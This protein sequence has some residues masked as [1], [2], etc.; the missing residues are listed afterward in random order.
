M[1]LLDV[2][3]VTVDNND[4]AI[5]VRGA[6][7][8]VTVRTDTGPI[9]VTDVTGAV[10]ASSADGGISLDGISGSVA[11][12]TRTGPIDANGLSGTR[13]VAKTLDG[14]ITLALSTAQDVEAHSQTGPISLTV[15]QLAGGYRISTQTVTGPTDV[16]VDSNPTAARSIVLDSQDGGIT[17]N[18]A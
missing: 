3:T 14:S 2:G 9:S 5:A 18:P 15:P 12:Q 7:G 17:V 16:N 11:V 1:D 10:S 8:D 6:A 13:T 4:G